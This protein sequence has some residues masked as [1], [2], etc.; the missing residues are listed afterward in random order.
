M[1]LVFIGELSSKIT[2]T[3]QNLN[4]EIPWRPLKDLR[5][6]IAHEYLGVDATQIFLMI[7]SEL[8]QIRPRLELLLEKILKD[9]PH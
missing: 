4:P 6:V 1:K 8:P 3:T 2:K 9:H 5:N 7:T